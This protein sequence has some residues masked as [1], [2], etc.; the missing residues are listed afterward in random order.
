MN[1]QWLGMAER[2][3]IVEFHDIRAERHESDKYLALVEGPLAAPFVG[4]GGALMGQFRVDA[5]PDRLLLLRGFP[6][7]PARRRSLTAFH[8]G[9]D[10]QRYRAEAAGLVRDTGVILARSLAASS[11]TRPLRAGAGYTA[12]VSELRFA[13]QLANYH[14]WL[15]LLLRK[16]G[17]DPL[18][19]YA[20]LESVNDVPAVPVIGGR[21]H[22][23]VLV[24]RGGNVPRVPPELRD[25]LRFAPEILGLSPAPALVW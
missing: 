7:M 2:L 14:L 17:L 1:D 3:P 24:P 20:T 16:A 15:R 6:S 13:E 18:A 11:A 23:I 5:H 4:A 19:A 12:I 25:M 8:A 9:P 10:W 21:T 22:H